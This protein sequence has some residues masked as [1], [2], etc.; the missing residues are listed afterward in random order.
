MPQC[1]SWIKVNEPPQPYC[2]Y[3]GLAVKQE[4]FGGCALHDCQTCCAIAGYKGLHYKKKSTIHLVG[5]GVDSKFHS[6]WVR[7]VSRSSLCEKWFRFKVHSIGRVI[8]SKYDVY[9][10]NQ[11]FKIFQGDSTSTLEFSDT[12]QTFS[13]LKSLDLKWCW[14]NVLRNMINM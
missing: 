10:N 4:L 5:L 6:K 14:V 9:R 12:S 11:S 3:Y 8:V 1:N 2:C 13:H 7:F